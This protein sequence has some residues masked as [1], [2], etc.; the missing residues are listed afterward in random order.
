VKQNFIFAIVIYVLMQFSSFIGIPLLTKF[1]LIDSNLKEIEQT[2][3]AAG[4]WATISFTVASILIIYLLKRDLLPSRNE[5]SGS[6]INSAMWAFNGIFIA[7]IGQG[8][9]A[10]IENKLFGIEPGSDNTKQIVDIAEVFPIFIFIIAIL[11]PILEEIIFRRIIYK[12]LADKYNFFVGATVS[13]I[14]FAIVHFDFEHLLIY[15]SMGFTFAFLYRITNNLLVP[16]VAHMSMN[17][18]VVMVQILFADKIQDFVEKNKPA[19]I[20]FNLFQ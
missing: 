7:L 9:A 1:N 18:I 4:L 6:L 10:S 15:L 16:I 2:Q 12:P 17:S 5:R 11:A 3:Y 8:I 14:F 20:L 13:S 19:F